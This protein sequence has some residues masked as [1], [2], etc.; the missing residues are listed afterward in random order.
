MHSIVQIKKLYIFQYPHYNTV[1]VK[2][3]I[4]L[5][6]LLSLEF[7]FSFWGVGK[8]KDIEVA[9]QN[10]YLFRTKHYILC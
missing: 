5:T 4:P 3:H 10:Y 6:P 7:A 9:V 8:G 2:M 1:L